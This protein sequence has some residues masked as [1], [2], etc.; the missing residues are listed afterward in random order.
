MQIFEFL[1][2]L[3]F[4]DHLFCSSLSLKFDHACFGDFKLDAVCGPRRAKRFLLRFC[5]Q[6]IFHCPVAVLPPNRVYLRGRIGFNIKLLFVDA[7]QTY[8][9][10]L[11]LQCPRH[12]RR[13]IPYAVLLLLFIPYDFEAADGIRRFQAFEIPLVVFIGG[14]CF[15]Q[16]SYLLHPPAFQLFQ[17]RFGGLHPLIFNGLADLPGF[18]FQLLPLSGA[19]SSGWSSS[20][21]TCAAETAERG[22]EFAGAVFQRLYAFRQLVL[23]AVK[24]R[25]DSSGR[26]LH[27]FGRSRRVAACRGGALRNIRQPSGRSLLNSAAEE[28]E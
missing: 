7:G 20:R 28:G 10:K 27:T 11:C 9:S 4:N 19:A 6:R 16:G 13:L 3:L 15:F 25:F 17:F 12:I 1:I 5:G 21:R 2:F 8:R 26:R 14:F 23:D 18:S 22:I 24:G